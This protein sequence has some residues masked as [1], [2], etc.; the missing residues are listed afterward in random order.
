MNKKNVL[1]AIGSGLGFAIGSTTNDVTYIMLG[2]VV[3]AGTG[4]MIGDVLE[5][6]EADELENNEPE[7]KGKLI[8]G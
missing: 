1:T 3:G 6:P 2:T 7:D 8:A 5:V 4:Y